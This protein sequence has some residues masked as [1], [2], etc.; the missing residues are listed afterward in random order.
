LQADWPEFVA[1][2]TSEV[3]AEWARR[4]KENAKKKVYHHGTGSCGYRIA[5]GVVP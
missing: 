5:K 4:N 3:G 1:Y 2:K